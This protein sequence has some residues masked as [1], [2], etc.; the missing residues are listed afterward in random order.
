MIMFE[1]NGYTKQFTDMMSEGFIFIDNRGIIRLYNNKAKEIFGIKDNN[2]FRH[3]VGI[4]E[5]GSWAPTAGKLMREILERMKDIKI[6][7]ES[8]LI[9]STMKQE[10]A[11]KMEALADSIIG[12][13]K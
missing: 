9:T 10:D 12:S 5:N 2:T 1:I 6:L 8:L 3:G 13:L 11:P 7:D 4:I